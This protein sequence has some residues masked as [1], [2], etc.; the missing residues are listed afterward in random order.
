[1]APGIEKEIFL[2][3]PNYKN[4]LMC[5]NLVKKFLNA[6]VKKSELTYYEMNMEIYGSMFTLKEDTWLFYNKKF[7]NKLYTHEELIKLIIG[8][9]KYF[10]NVL[11]KTDVILTSRFVLGIHNDSCCIKNEKELLL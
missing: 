7:E 8:K 5:N 9:F 2:R 11:N 10:E 1:M 4:F 6:R 3:F